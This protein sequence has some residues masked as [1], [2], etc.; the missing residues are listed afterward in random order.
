MEIREIHE[1]CIHCTPIVT[2]TIRIGIQLDQEHNGNINHMEN[3]F[4]N[5]NQHQYLYTSYT[6]LQSSIRRFY[7]MRAYELECII[8]SCNDIHFSISFQKLFH[9]LYSE[10]NIIRKRNEFCLK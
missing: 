10:R 5:F 3:I 6:K 8:L 2:Y 7:V 9:L 4:L 1:S